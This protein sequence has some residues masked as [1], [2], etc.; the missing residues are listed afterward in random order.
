MIAGF[1]LPYAYYQFRA[2]DAPQA[3]PFVC[4]YYPGDNDFA[5]DDVNYVS[6]NRL[7]VELYSDNV[8]FERERVIEAALRA[9]G[10]PFARTHVYIDNER[11]Y[12]TSYNMEVC[13]NG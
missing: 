8:D 5:A 4:F 6:I 11:M 9:A 2:E 13:I 3:P 12:Q 10:L 7:V 1:G